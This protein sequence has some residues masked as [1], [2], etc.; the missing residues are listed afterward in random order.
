[1]ELS[2]EE[3][4]GI[5]EEEKA[6]IEA[7]EKLKEQQAAGGD[8]STTN[9]QPNVAGLLCYLGVWVTGIIFLLIEQKNKFVRFHAIQSIIVFV[10]LGIASAFL[11]QIPLVGWFFGA[12][13]G[14]LSF[15]LW[16]VLMVKAYHGQLYKVVLAGDLAERMS[17]V[18]ADKETTESRK[19]EE[20]PKPATQPEP[21]SSPRTP[22]LGKK[23]SDKADYYLKSTKFGRITSSSL[24]IAWSFAFLI[25]FHY[26]NKYIAYYQYET[27]G[28][29][30]YPILTEAFGAWLPIL[31]VALTLSIAGHIIL[32]I[33]DRYILRETTLII[34]NLFGIAVVLTLLS[35]FPFNFSAIPNATMADIAPIIATVVLIGITVGLAI[36][37][38]VSFIKLIVNVSTKS[39]SY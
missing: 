21:P 13:I 12:I 9:L 20:Y 32:I 26:F 25:F 5:Y 24:A 19:K 10:A 31:T 11:S 23:A 17:T 8:V 15:V 30:R 14:V 2:P 34:L 7:E 27:A 6:Q 22:D 28:W 35:I 37:T 18:S 36:G 33:F 1:M 3:K 4:R 39:P 29:V 38:L 16:I